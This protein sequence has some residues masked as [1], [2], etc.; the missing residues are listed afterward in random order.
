MVYLEGQLQ[1]R[2]CDD[3]VGEIQQVDLQRVKHA[4][5]AHNDSLGLLLNWQGAHQSSHL[6]DTPQAPQKTSSTAG[7]HWITGGEVDSE[8]KALTGW[9]GGHLVIETR[10]V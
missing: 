6:H 1:L 8:V 3:N 7:L 5:P 9:D 4:L 10:V 2:A